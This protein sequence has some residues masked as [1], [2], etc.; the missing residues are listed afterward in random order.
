MR[1]QLVVDPVLV[2]LVEQIKVLVPER[3]QEAVGVAEL[4]DAPVRGGGA[5]LVAADLAALRDE[6]LKEALGGED[7]HRQDRRG[8]VRRQDDS[9][10]SGVAKEGAHDEPGA[11]PVGARVH[12][13][14][15]VGRTVAGLQDGLDVGLGEGHFRR[16]WGRVRLHRDKAARHTK[17]VPVS[18]CS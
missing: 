14:H 15:G 6:D 10:A 11:A 1:A 9:A 16:L 8:A 13:K 5:Q 2:A 4:A 7:L 17:T 18:P 3:R 12:P